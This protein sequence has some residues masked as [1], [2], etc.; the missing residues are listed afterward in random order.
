MDPIIRNFRSF[1]PGQAARLI[2][3]DDSPP[4]CTMSYSVIE[5][6]QTSAHQWEHVIYVL[7]GSGTL[8]CGGKSFTVSEGDAVLVPPNTLH[9][10]KNETQSPMLR[11]TFNPLAS[12]AHEG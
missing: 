10:W 7:E 5:P 6:G 3:L 8:V 11:V 4:T 2:S 1:A 12:A 9:Q